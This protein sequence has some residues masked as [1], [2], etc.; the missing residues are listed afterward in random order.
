M[1]RYAMGLG[2]ALTALTLAGC[3]AMQATGGAPDD[4]MMMTTDEARAIVEARNAEFEALFA[5][6]D[7][8]GIATLMYAREGRLVPPDAPDMVGVAAIAGYWTGVMTA[9]ETVELTTAE[10]L[11]VGEGY[12]AE[13]THVVIYDA[14]GAAMGGGK[15]VILWTLEDGVWKMQWDGWNYGPVE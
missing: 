15:A 8:T 4:A 6:D 10:A 5:A 11:P 13:R 9:I 1:N 12:I 7:A 14:D 2:A 3:D